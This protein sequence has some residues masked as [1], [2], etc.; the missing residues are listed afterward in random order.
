MSENQAPMLEV[1][2]LTK[3]F[4][5]SPP[6][7]NRVLNGTG[8]ISLKAVENVD[9]KI[10]KGKHLAWLENQ[11]AGNQLSLVWSSGFMNRQLVLSTWKELILEG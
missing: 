6:L 2:G 8:K 5:V 10:P 9:F 4:D 11:G 3:H 1:R 7:L